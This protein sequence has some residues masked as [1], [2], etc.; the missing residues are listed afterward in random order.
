M[1]ALTDIQIIDHILYVFV[2]DSRCE[3]VWCVYIVHET[4]SYFIN[5]MTLKGF[6]TL[7]FLFV[8]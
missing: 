2:R 8:L 6:Q 7:F 3:R 1:V 4:F 5:R